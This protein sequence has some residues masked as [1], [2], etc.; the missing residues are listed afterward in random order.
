[1]CM[2]V[3]SEVSSVGREDYW[4]MSHWLKDVLTE[5]CIIPVDLLY[6]LMNVRLQ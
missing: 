5:D 2:C 4:T 3:S 1:M 6:F